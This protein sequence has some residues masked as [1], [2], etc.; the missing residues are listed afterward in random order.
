MPCTSDQDIVA[1]SAK[2]VISIALICSYGAT[3][4]LY[5]CSWGSCPFAVYWWMDVKALMMRAICPCTQSPC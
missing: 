2:Q 1:A 4:S 5:S 3:G